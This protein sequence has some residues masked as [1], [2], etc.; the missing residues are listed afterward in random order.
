MGEMGKAMSNRMNSAI[1]KKYV[2]I[3]SSLS[4]QKTARRAQTGEKRA[5]DRQTKRK[6]I[7]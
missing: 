1:E 6:A 7:R 3:Y 2:P 5:N 4:A